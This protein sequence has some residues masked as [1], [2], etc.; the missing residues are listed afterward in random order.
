MVD[1]IDLGDRAVDRR[2]AV[3]TGPI[4][5]GDYYS[6]YQ[7]GF[8]RARG[9]RW[10][11]VSLVLLTSVVTLPLLALMLLLVA[12]NGGS[13]VYTQKRIGLR[14]REF[15]LYK[16]RTMVPDAD[17]ALQQI[18]KSDSDRA[19]EWEMTQK[20]RD[21]PRVT[22]LGRFLRA[23][24]LDELPQFWNVLRGDMSLVGPRPMMPDQKSLYSGRV[25]CDL[26]PGVTGLWQ[27][28]ARNAESFSRRVDYDKDY[29]AQLSLWFDV[30]L[31]FRTV[32][33]VLR[34]TGC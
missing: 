1:V 5:A 11:D 13:P 7:T 20:L 2:P 31:L 12:L 14:G 8:Y 28:S 32:L 24:S 23:S 30:R 17:G 29:E 9:K 22:R 4:E 26:R 25:Y 33:V 16:L 34:G 18:L 6:A 21:D 10:M 27:V 19:R 15:N 3:A